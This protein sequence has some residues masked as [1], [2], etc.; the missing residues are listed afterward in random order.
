MPDATPSMTEPLARLDRWLAEHRPEYYQ[1]LQPGVSPAELD[2]FEEL[3][4]FKLYPALRELYLWRNGQRDTT[5]EERSRPDHIG[6]GLFWINW[7]FSPLQRAVDSWRSLTGLLEGGDFDRPHH[8]DRHWVPFLSEGGGDEVCVDHRG[9]WTN[10]VGQIIRFDHEG[11][12]RTVL[13]PNPECWLKQYVESLEAGHWGVETQQMPW[14]PYQSF[15]LIRGDEPRVQQYPRRFD[16]SSSEDPTNDGNPDWQSRYALRLPED[17]TDSTDE[18]DYRTNPLRIGDSVP[19]QGGPF[20]GMQGQV[21]GID[22]ETDSIHVNMIVFGR[23]IPMGLY[24]ATGL[25]DRKRWTTG[26]Q[27]RGTLEHL[28]NLWSGRK[29]RLFVCACVRRNIAIFPADPGPATIDLT[30]HFADHYATREELRQ[31]WRRNVSG[32]WFGNNTGPTDWSATAA[33]MGERIVGDIGHVMYQGT[34]S[35][36]SYRPGEEPHLI[37]LLCHI[38]GDPSRLAPEGGPYP[39]AVVQLAESVYQQEQ[40]AIGP[41]HDALLDAGLTELAEHFADKSEWH[42]KG[43]W[44]LDWLTGRK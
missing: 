27:L 33:Q 24:N 41:L 6:G 32:F 34:R 14:G 12:E 43:C 19:I 11:G 26:G 36:L 25:V 23:P 10:Q 44:A 5:D 42:P 28:P 20:A 4:G 35:L 30:E 8:W 1:R 22:E 17:L 7:T 38:L 3:I 9:L 39:A 18:R 2:D 29:A 21:T 37:R 15:E 13:A 16:P 40:A 31:A